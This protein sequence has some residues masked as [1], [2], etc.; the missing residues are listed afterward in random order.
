MEGMKRSRPIVLP[1]SSLIPGNCVIS[2]AP[3][4]F[5]HEVT[6]SQPFYVEGA[7]VGS[8]TGEFAAGT[9]VALLFHDGG[10]MCRV[11]DGAGL[12]VKTRFDGL[13]KL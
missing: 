9:K 11:V 7:P 3:N 4:Q 2:P 8:P 1:N 10:E 12:Y 6:A 13:R 5:T